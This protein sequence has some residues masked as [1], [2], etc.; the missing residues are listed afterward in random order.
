MRAARPP[1]IR[2]QET[3]ELKQ[4]LAA[5]EQQL[6]AKDE[7]L[8]DSLPAPLAVALMDAAKE[9]RREERFY[10]RPYL[11]K[12]VARQ[13]HAALSAAEGHLA[14]QAQQPHAAEEAGRD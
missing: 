10:K 8:A 4:Q 3:E 2:G 6:A 1:R 12:G 13:L 7:Q 11:S 9:A 14:Q 5:L